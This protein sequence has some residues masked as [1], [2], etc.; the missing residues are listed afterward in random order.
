ME[1]G[2]DE[3]IAAQMVGIQ[4]AGDNPSR[5]VTSRLINHQ[6][7]ASEA[8]RMSLGMGATGRYQ[9]F[10]IRSQIRRWTDS[11]WQRSLAQNQRTENRK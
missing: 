9:R 10:E 11:P 5:R 4:M 2:R 8:R 7:S 1:A 6:E 3:M